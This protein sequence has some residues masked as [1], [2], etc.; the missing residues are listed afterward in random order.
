VS[1]FDAGNWPLGLGICI[2]LA[3][4]AGGT[5]IYFCDKSE[6]PGRYRL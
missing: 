6:H 1:I 2:V 5:I 3:S 4:L